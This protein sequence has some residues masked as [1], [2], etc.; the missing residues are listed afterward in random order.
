MRRD[1]EK[2][3]EAQGCGRPVVMINTYIFLGTGHIYR[4]TFNSSSLAYHTSR[5]GTWMGGVGRR[6]PEDLTSRGGIGGRTGL[7]DGQGGMDG[8]TGQLY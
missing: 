2:K 8:R 3:R 5:Y 6:K 4:H 1:V 7:A